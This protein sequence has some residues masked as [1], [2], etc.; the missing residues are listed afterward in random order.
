MSTNKKFNYVFHTNRD[1]AGL[2]TELPFIIWK[3]LKKYKDCPHIT[4]SL[5]STL[6]GKTQQ[7]NQ[8]NETNTIKWFETSTRELAQMAGVQQTII[9][10][11]VKW[12]VSKELLTISKGIDKPQK[13]CYK[14][15]VDTINDWISQHQ[16]ND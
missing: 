13:R 2:T 4:L 9:E 11:S 5:L 3:E 14:L 8:R 12:L 7:I 1:Y 15:A 6:I 16:Y 10:R